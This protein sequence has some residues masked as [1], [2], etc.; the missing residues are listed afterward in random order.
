MRIQLLI[1]SLL[2]SGAVVAQKQMR[3]LYNLDDRG[4]KPSGWHF[5]PGI[6]YMIPSKGKRQIQDEQTNETLEL[7]ASGKIGLYAEV[8]RHHLFDKFYFLNHLDYGIAYKKLAGKQKSSIVCDDC[9]ATVT[10]SIFKDNFASV[11]V[12]FSNIWQISDYNFIQ[13]G[14]GINGDYRFPLNQ[15]PETPR[16]PVRQTAPQPL[17]VQ[18]HYKF[19]FGI[20]AEKGVFILPS[21]EIPILNVVPFDGWRSTYKYFDSGYRPI[22]F[23]IKFMFLSK[24]KPEDCK[25][26]TDGKTGHKLWDSKM[27]R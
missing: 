18:L 25:G 9:D 11:Y 26:S 22:I 15:Q 5:A 4:M 17:E 12:N 8:G 10:E 20:K 6:T 3:P 7:Q 14:L 23:S 24:R 27:R 1:I 21:I 13:N 19:S 2:L 16:I